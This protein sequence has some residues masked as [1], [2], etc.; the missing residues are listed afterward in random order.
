[1]TQLMRAMIL[2][3]WLSISVVMIATVKLMACEYGDSLYSCGDLPY[4]AFFLGGFAVVGTLPF[5]LVDLIE[6]ANRS[7]R[8]ED[9]E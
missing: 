1:M 3:F 7:V 2:G 9:T 8:P 5:V 6:Q 4:L